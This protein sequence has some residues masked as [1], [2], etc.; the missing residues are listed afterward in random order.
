MLM[1]KIIFE[2]YLKCK[3]QMYLF[4]FFMKKFD[5][6]DLKSKCQTCALT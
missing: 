1:S 5:F 6:D 4:F 3:Q 2:I